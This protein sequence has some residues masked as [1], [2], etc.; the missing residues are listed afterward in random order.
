ME[1]PQL[2]EDW[3]E[4]I[5]T[6][7]WQ[8][9]DMGLERMQGMVRSL[10]LSR[11]AGTVITVAGTNGKGST[12]VA[13]EALLLC[14]GKRVGTTL[15][16][17]VQRF[18]ERIRVAGAEVEDD[19][20]CEA[21]AAVEGARGETPLTY[22][23]FAALASLW[24]FRQ[25]EVDVAILEI[26]L[27]GRLDAYNV[28]DADIAVITS[29]GLDHQSFLG[30]TRE[31]IG[32]EKAGILR[33]GQQVVLGPDMPVA[34]RHACAEL[35]LTPT[36]LGESHLLEID[37]GERCWTL[38]GPQTTEVERVPMGALAPQNLALAY[39]AAGRVAALPDHVVGK[40]SQQA[41]IPGRMQQVIRD[42]RTWLLDVAHNPA[43]AAFLTQALADR[44]LHPS[45]VVCG[46]L[47]DKDHAGVIAGIRAELDAPWLLVDTIA[48]R[49]ISG[50]ELA[51][52]GGL[53]VAN[54]VSWSDLFDTVNSA[55]QPGDVILLFGSFNVIERFALLDGA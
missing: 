8:S 49:G 36:V 46:M 7:H 39:L 33:P 42:D 22:F 43:G 52:R 27:G 24:I 28:I 10:G 26:G 18:N 37:A 14:A 31:A 1:H 15:S 55:T 45:L 20:I 12:C 30:N 9:I 4:Y 5:S 35:G 47:A 32:A 53:E 21:F 17:H 19:L 3:L 51:E 48:E 40:V 2:L 25:A 54:P 44:G 29:I 41:A 38:H 16:P 6:R 50:L 34:V 11:P 13:A 23:E